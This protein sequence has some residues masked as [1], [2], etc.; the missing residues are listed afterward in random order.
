MVC[1][2]RGSLCAIAALLLAALPWTNAARADLSSQEFVCAYGS[3]GDLRFDSRAGL[4]RASSVNNTLYSEVPC[5]PQT[6]KSIADR[7]KQQG[8]CVTPT[9]SA[10]CEA[11]DKRVKAARA[12]TLEASEAE[13]KGATDPKK[14]GALT[15]KKDAAPTRASATPAYPGAPVKKCPF[16]SQSFGRCTADVFYGK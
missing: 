2:Q 15:A 7:E 9:A 16:G 1:R 10:R 3:N 4:R 5:A 6:L 11:L 14:A 12:E 8:R 13:R